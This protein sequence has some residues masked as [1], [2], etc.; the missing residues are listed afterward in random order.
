MARI[1]LKETDDFPESK[2]HLLRSMATADDLSE[3]YRHLLSDDERNVYRVIGHQPPALESFRSYASTV[4]ENLAVTE[5][6]CEL[7]ILSTASEL[8]SAY[9]WHQHVRIGLDAG[10]LPEEI[11]AIEA[12]DLDDFSAADR[13]LSRYVRGVVRGSVTEQLHEQ[14]RAHY[15]EK[16][17]V[18]IGLLAGVYLTIAQLLDAFAVETEEPFVGWDLSNL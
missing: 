7:V 4:R 8:R 1:S 13:A 2:Q 9:E 10:L 16:T 11:Q 18:G 3:Q 17:M 6:Q 14:A 5:R 15:D 12:D